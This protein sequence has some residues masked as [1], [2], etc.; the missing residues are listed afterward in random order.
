MSKR[1]KT[2][3][4]WD[5]S[6]CKY[7]PGQ[8]GAAC[9]LINTYARPAYAGVR[10]IYTKYRKRSAASRKQFA[11]P[12]ISKTRR[13]FTGFRRKYGYRRRFGRRRGSW[14]RYVNRKLTRLSQQPINVRR[15][16]LTGQLIWSTNQCNYTGAYALTADQIEANLATSNILVP[17]VDTNGTYTGSL[18]RINQPSNNSDGNNKSKILNWVSVYRFRNNATMP[19]KLDAYWCFCKK[20]HDVVYNDLL[21]DGFTDA[22]MVGA[23]A[24][25]DVNIYPRDNRTFQKFWRIRKHRHMEIPA[26]GEVTLKLVRRKPFYYDPAQFDTSAL[27]Y[28]KGVSQLL[29]VRGHG[30]IS[31]DATTHTEV[32][33]SNGTLDWK[34][35]THCK[36]VPIVDQN[37][38]LM[39]SANNL[40]AQAAGPTVTIEPVEEEKMAL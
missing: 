7:L 37:Y 31:H 34:Y 27:T 35:D 24:Y 13:T 20:D 21:T 30:V 36:W 32:G 16:N 1:I 38:K 11:M 10:N 40:G 3:P 39:Q 19:A 25:N 22:G 28:L 17:D 33:T 26:G 18:E 14:K 6:Y 9:N 23:T 4:L 2:E 5:P 12:G 8:Y 29:L 15:Y